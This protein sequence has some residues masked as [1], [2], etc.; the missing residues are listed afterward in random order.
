MPNPLSNE[1]TPPTK[2]GNNEG[3]PRI[4]AIRDTAAQHGSRG[5][6]GCR[7]GNPRAVHMRA[8][9]RLA[10]RLGHG[11]SGSARP[12][13]VAGPGA[14]C[15]ATK[16]SASW[17]GVVWASSTRRVR[18]KL[19]RLVALKMILA[20]DHAGAQEQA[21]FRTEAEAVA[22]LQQPNIIQIYEVGEQDG[23]PFFPWNTWTAAALPASWTARPWPRARPRN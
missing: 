1:S 12:D 23:R 15:P 19:N 22:R 13:T 6:D 18:V 21:R 14:G 11:G 7:V 16:F 3:P 20:G 9:R 8:G 10:S 2:P 17:G 5:R 4:S